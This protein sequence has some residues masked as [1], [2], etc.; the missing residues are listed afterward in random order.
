MDVSKVDAFDLTTHEEGV[1][2]ICKIASFCCVPAE[3]LAKIY[4]IHSKILHKAI[5]WRKFCFCESIL[6]GH[7]FK[8][9]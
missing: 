6:S 7:K 8:I 9:E 4:C 5:Q 2:G 1:S 3:I